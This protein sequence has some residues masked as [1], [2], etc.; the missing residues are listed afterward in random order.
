MCREEG[1]RGI[2]RKEGVGRGIRYII[3]MCDMAKNELNRSFMC[4]CSL[5]VIVYIIL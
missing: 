3:Y 4:I 1:V 2:G 5:V